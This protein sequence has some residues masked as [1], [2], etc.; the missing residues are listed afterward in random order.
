MRDFTQPP[1]R[2]RQVGG[3]VL[4]AVLAITVAVMV[5]DPGDPTRVI[6]AGAAPSPR[7]R[8]TPSPRS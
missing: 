8:P 5:T 3:L 6:P 1:D 7:N 2:V 4:A